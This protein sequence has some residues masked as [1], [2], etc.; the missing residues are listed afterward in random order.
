MYKNIIILFSLLFW[1]ATKGYA[2]IRFVN[3]GFQ[4]SFNVNRIFFKPE[5]PQR[6]TVLLQPA[7]YLQHFY[8]T[9]Y[10]QSKQKVTDGSL[11]GG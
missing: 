6:F 7:V 3:L 9:V 11:N 4:A 1:V 2:R 5:V 10:N 8:S